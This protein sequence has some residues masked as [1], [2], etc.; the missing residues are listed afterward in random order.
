MR[1]ILQRCLNGSVEINNKINGKCN[2]GYVILVGFTHTDSDNIVDKMVNKIVNLRIFDDENGKINKSILDVNGSVLSISQ[3]TLY[4]N[5]KEGRRPSFIEAMKSD[6][7]TTLY[8][9]FNKK[10]SEILKVETGIF[11]ADMKVSILNDGPFTILLDS[12]EF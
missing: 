12:N 4:A 9:Y 1:V 2:I 5:T 11:G 6:H 3:F 8:N 7:A 10:L